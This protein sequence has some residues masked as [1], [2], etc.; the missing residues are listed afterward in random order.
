MIKHYYPHLYAPEGKKLSH[1]NMGTL[2]INIIRGAITGLF[3]FFFIINCLERPISQEGYIVDIWSTSI[4]LYSSILAMVSLRLCFYTRDYNIF[5]VLTYFTLQ[6]V[7]Y[8]IFLAVS[9]QNSNFAT[10]RTASET[11]SSFKFY[12][13]LLLC[14]G[15]IV[16]TDVINLIL[17]KEIWTPLSLFFTSIINKGRDNEYKVFEN[18]INHLKRKNK[19]RKL[20]QKKNETED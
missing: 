5:T 2:L 8:I 4:I 18:L 14:L 15:I 13:I 7:M 3:M 17:R 11:A 10:F 16:I 9:D 19:I 1:F 20:L 12:I 6:I